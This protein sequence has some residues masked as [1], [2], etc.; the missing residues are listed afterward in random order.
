MPAQPR[1]KGYGDS[2]GEY[3]GRLVTDTIET[4]DIDL[5]KI[6]KNNLSDTLEL[7]KFEEH[8]KDFCLARLGFPVVRVELTPFQIKT[9]I[10][11]AVTLLSYHAPL[12]SRNYVTFEA[13]VGVGTYELPFHVINNLSYV[14][15]KKGL[16]TSNFPAESFESDAFISYFT[17]YQQ[18]LYNNIGDFLLLQQSLETMRKILGNEGTFEVINNKYVQLYPTPESNQDVI[19][20]YRAIDSNTIS[21]AY[22]S[23]LQKYSLAVCKGVLGEIRGKYA[24]LPS[25]GGGAVLNGKDLLAASVKE[26]EE[27]EKQLQNAIEEPPTFS[28]F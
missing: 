9:C 22:M 8:I 13:S 19:V 21:P 26:K 23:W 28:M 15:Y 1:L 11:E 7:N 20:E 6:N 4:G 25:P 27:L 17:G 14:V 5:Q 16:M 12:W 24:S 18:G 10:D 3:G 2:F